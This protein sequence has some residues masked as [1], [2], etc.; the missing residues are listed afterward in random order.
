MPKAMNDANIGTNVRHRGM[1]QA[2]RIDAESSAAIVPR[3]SG[4][5][6]PPWYVAVTPQ[7]VHLRRAPG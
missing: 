4:T 5:E 3:M 1:R 7:A 6:R 2:M